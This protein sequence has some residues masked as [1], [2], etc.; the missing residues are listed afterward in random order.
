MLTIIDFS[1][2]PCFELLSYLQVNRKTDNVPSAI[3]ME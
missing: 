3:C 2:L 1:S